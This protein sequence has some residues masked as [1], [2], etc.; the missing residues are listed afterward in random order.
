MTEFKSKQ[1]RREPK[2]CGVCGHKAIGMCP[3]NEEFILN[4]EERHFRRLKLEA[5]RRQRKGS[6]ETSATPA[7]PHPSSGTASPD[8]TMTSFYSQYS[9]T[10]SDSSDMFAVNTGVDTNNE[11][12]LL[13]VCTADATP[14]PSI[15]PITNTTAN[16]LDTD[17][18]A[19]D[20]YGEQLVPIGDDHQLLEIG[21][22]DRNNNN[23]HSF[24]AADD[25]DIADDVYEKVVQFEL[26]IIPI[27]TDSSAESTPFNDSER[28]VLRELLNAVHNSLIDCPKTSS[29]TEIVTLHELRQTMGYIWEREIQMI[30][31]F[32]KSLQ[33]F[34]RLC[35]T[36]R[37]ALLKNSSFEVL[38][39]LSIMR[40]N[41]AAD[42]LTLPMV[43]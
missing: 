15:S 14:L 39:L 42:C 8:E 23:N 26:S 22:I 13:S 32:M 37:I 36:D 2:I 21:T 19:Y 38:Y 33:S 12:S 9:E 17:F 3:I 7:T 40:Y 18:F 11:Y 24:T 5:K 16:L 25:T 41:P 4:D 27:A 31:A 1:S 29:V 28:K 20:N 35:E 43:S 10:I 34:Q 30:V 6:G